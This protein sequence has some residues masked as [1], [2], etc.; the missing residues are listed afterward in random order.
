V[1]QNLLSASLKGKNSVDSFTER[2]KARGAW[3]QGVFGEIRL[4]EQLESN[5]PIIELVTE[6]L[7]SAGQPE[8]ARFI[9][10]DIVLDGNSVRL[11]GWTSGEYSNANVFYRASSIKAK[12]YLQAW[13]YHLL[14]NK[15]TYL[16][17]LKDKKEEC[18]RFEPLSDD[19]ERNRQLAG[20][21]KLFIEG[22]SKP[23]DFW[24]EVALAYME[25]GKDEQKAD[26]AM[27]EAVL[28]RKNHQKPGER[29]R[30]AQEISLIVQGRDV[31]VFLTEAFYQSADEV[32]SMMLARSKP[33]QES[34]KESV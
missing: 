4:Q 20:L 6:T 19:K 7:S 26:T 18:I 11:E 14:G 15:T 29:Y 24:P 1:N 8:P 16:I 25:A 33:E 30:I 13:I 28:G 27:D 31:N 3:M 5:A 17:G 22:H 32:F 21:L 23:S 10:R 12:D 34:T 2:L 9:E